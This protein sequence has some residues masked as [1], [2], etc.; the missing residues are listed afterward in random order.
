VTLGTGLED[1][2]GNALASPYQLTFTTAA[3]TDTTR[4]TLVSST[5]GDAGKGAARRPTVML[6]FSEAM[7]LGSVESAFSITSPA[8]PTVGSFTFVWSEDSTEVSIT[9][10]VTYDYGTAITWSLGSG[11]RDLAGNTLASDVQ[12]SFQVRRKLSVEVT[13]E[14]ALDGYVTRWPDGA[15]HSVYDASYLLIGDNGTS[16]PKYINRSFLSFVFVG[17]GLVP[18]DALGIA[19]AELRVYLKSTSGAPE[20]IGIPVLNHV[21]YGATLAN[22]DYDVPTL[23]CDSDC[24]GERT[25]DMPNDF[26]VGYKS[27]NVTGAVAADFVDRAARGNRVQFRLRMSGAETYTGNSIS[28]YVQYGT[29]E[30]GGA[31]EA[32]YLNVEFEVP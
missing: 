20:R 14:S 16:P 31:G 17:D 6:R 7:D 23:A 27:A 12:R 11:A 32:P 2:A 25:Y 19:H 26:S 3:T 30:F 21:A 4:P 15:G 5:P 29:N 1:A 22:D 13:S 24:A 8:S 10:N 9:P 18:E 28:N